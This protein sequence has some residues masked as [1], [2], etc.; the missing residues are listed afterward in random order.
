MLSLYRTALAIRRREP[1]LHD[2]ELTWL[3]LSEHV[4]AFVRGDIISVTNLSDALVPLPPHQEILL[5][6]A[7]LHAGLLPADSTAWLRTGA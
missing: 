3:N 1:A 6:S 2:A 4:L 7:P 5:T